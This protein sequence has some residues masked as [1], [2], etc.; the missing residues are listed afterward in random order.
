MQT[1]V[2]HYM[3]FARRDDLVKDHTRQQTVIL[4]TGENELSI[5]ISNRR[6]YLF[7]HESY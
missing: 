2:I 5:I 1:E 7:L 3:R 6:L 4:L